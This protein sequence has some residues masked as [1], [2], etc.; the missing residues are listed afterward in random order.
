MTPAN[1]YHAVAQ[2]L[3]VSYFGRP[4]D[5]N[6]LLALSA[7]LAAAGAPA[8]SAGLNA[9]YRLNAQVRALLDSF[10]SSEESSV[11]YGTSAPGFDT[12]RFV[13]Q[14]YNNLFGRTPDPGGLAFWTKAIDSGSLTQ[15]G[16]AHAILTGALAANSA[17]AALINKK[18]AFATM[19]TDAM[20]TPFEVYVYQGNMAAQFGRD[21]LA[22]VTA[23]SDPS[24]FPASVEATLAQ[25]STAPRLTA[26]ADQ[27]ASAAGVTLFLADLDG[28]NGTL[29]TG[30]NLSGGDAIDTLRAVLGATAKDQVPMPATRNIENILVHAAG[31][32]EPPGQTVL[33]ATLM[34]GVTRWENDH[35]RGD[36]IIKNVGIQSG[37]LPEDVTIAMV[38]SA[39]GNADFAV[40]FSPSAL[41]ASNPSTSSPTIRLQLMDTRASDAGGAPLK[42]SPY[43][44]VRF[45]LNKVPVQ[46]RSA[47][48]DQAQTY[49][50]LLGAIRAQL[51]ATPGLERL[52]AS[53]GDPF[54][55]YDT[56]SGHVLAGR[57]IL[58]TNTGPGSIGVAPG[59][60]W[61]QAGSD[62]GA[63]S[64]PGPSSGATP[65]ITGTIV[66]DN[67]GRGGIG[68]DLLVGG[69][70]LG[71]AV[72]FDP[73]I[74]PRSGFEAFN[75]TVE[76]TSVLQTIK[77]TDNTLQ[78]VNLSNG[79][80]KGDVILRG[81]ADVNVPD[82]P[83]DGTANYGRQYSGP[84]GF[85]D[86]RQ[87]DAAAM[88]GKVDF[89][90]LI[91][92]DSANKY[93]AAPGTRSGAPTETVD[94]DYAG[95]SNN[96]SLLVDIDYGA[97]SSRGIRLAGQEDFRF[98][99]SGG[100]GDDLLQ[101]HVVPGPQAGKPWTIDQDLNNNV[102]LSGGDGN[103]TI[104]KPGAGD[105][106]LDGGAGNDTLYAENTG[107]QRVQLPG[108][109]SSSFEAV[110]VNAHWVFNT[111]D[112]STGLAAART[113][114]RL[115]SDAA[116]S[117][118]L[119]G[120][121]VAVNFRGID[122]KVTV[123]TTLLTPASSDKE[124]NEAIKH[125]INDD[126]VLGKL[127]LAQD[128]PG[129]S[130]IVRALVD[131]AM[132]TGHL[133]VTLQASDVADRAG[134]AAALAAFDAKGD[135][136]SALA[137]NRDTV[138]LDLETMELVTGGASHA[139]SD[140]LITPGAGDDVVVLG[141]AEGSDTAQSS[142]DTLLFGRQFGSDTI[143]GFG[144]NG[145]GID[146]LDFSALGGVILSDSPMLDK[147]ITIAAASAANDTEAKIGALFSADN[148]L[149]Q[150]HVFARVDAS[151]N[152]A[153]MY[154]IVDAPGAGNAV[155]TLEGSID[156]VQVAWLDGLAG[157]NF[158]NAASAGYSQAE[159]ASSAAATPLQLVGVAPAGDMA[160][161]VNSGA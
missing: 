156:L 32:I 44:G 120:A 110:D 17:D 9:A 31:T 50:E 105:A 21:L 19:F 40:Y 59:A 18:V 35:S 149:A 91:T 84:Y 29:Q 119:T 27:L 56:R 12:V 85:H 108:W 80:A 151:G 22:R 13:S 104:R 78:V 107:G 126:A 38:G 71:G 127:L 30:D 82:T 146:H 96:D 158:V 4:A 8:H 113:I 136:R 67:V 52:V 130:L 97:A 6:G 161:S 33:D 42:D 87:V 51:A 152:A 157:A 123:G 145:P 118:Q 43:D 66:L 144:V 81:I 125:A 88:S 36:L 20:D 16:A 137:V 45:L 100:A 79:A 153:A 102:T 39:A 75:I 150:T 83:L 154:S 48:I 86:V 143:V 58:I 122:S 106:V 34:S 117:Y 70:P 68:G 47:A 93:I 24:T 109:P 121:R 61:L 10:G 69:K 11:L 7:A 26:A 28:K 124:I 76:R 101:V 147:S 142:N 74:H 129:S 77:S 64:A 2:E 46:V 155:A 159:G 140:N 131:G 41:R 72:S 73:G 5:P 95:G 89:S 53:L 1:A 98:H 135:Y 133:R 160:G 139:A 148:A 138:G 92:F 37:Q 115:V 62:E 112:Q 49:D 60:G 99:I 14:I 25:L 55:A 94:F 132:D 111:A 134:I 54:Q 114:E 15:A 103:D 63:G 3:Y 141:T 65:L 57:E 90:V 116:D 128:G 23:S